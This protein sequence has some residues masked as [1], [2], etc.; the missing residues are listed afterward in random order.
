VTTASED[1]LQ[2]AMIAVRD[3][4]SERTMADLFRSLVRS[5]LLVPIRRADDRGVEIAVAT[6]AKGTT[7]FHGF[8]SEHALRRAIPE[9]ATFVEMAVPALAEAALEDPTGELVVDAGSSVGGRLN[10]RDLELLQ[11]GLLPGGGDDGAFRAEGTLRVFALQA[12]PSD[13]LLVAARTAFAQEPAVESA[14]SF[15]GELG[16]GPRHLFLGLRLRDGAA[17]AAEV[18]PRIS[19][20]LRPALP[21]D[22]MLDVVELSAAQ[23]EVVEVT[24]HRVWPADDPAAPGGSRPRRMNDDI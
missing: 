9:G 16:R 1:E 10:R 24:G 11:E 22:S 15:E 18:L 7:A 12:P 8:T 14:H 13:E 3:D 2:R 20:A 4:R 5:H 23:L 6:D 21:P 17:S 19:Q